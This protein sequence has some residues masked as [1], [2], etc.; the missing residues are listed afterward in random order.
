MMREVA[1]HPED[2]RVVERV[3]AAA[4]QAFQ[5]E[6]LAPSRLGDL[7]LAVDLGVDVSSAIDVLSIVEV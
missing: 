5:L 3:A 2:I 6:G 1:Q 7:Q 4:F